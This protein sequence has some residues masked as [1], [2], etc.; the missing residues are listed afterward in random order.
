MSESRVF[1]LN[2]VSVQDVAERVKA[3]LRDEK[4]MKVQD[5]PDRNGYL[6]QAA[7]D[8]TLKTLSGMKLATTVQLVVSGERL[9]VTVGEGQ[10]ADKLGAG[11]VGLF[12]L[13]PLAVTAGIGAYKQKMLPSEIFDVIM[14]F[15]SSSGVSARMGDTARA[16]ESSETVCPK[17]G[18]KIPKGSKFCNNC[19]ERIDCCPQCGA[20]LVPGSRF[21]SEC[22]RQL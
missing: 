6:I 9:E 15:T 10:W 12:L 4:N 18:A 7:Q 22:G 13:W 8:D 5:A 1:E 3:F 16:P 21:C 19:G 14:R 2:G 20:Q 17:C 11:A